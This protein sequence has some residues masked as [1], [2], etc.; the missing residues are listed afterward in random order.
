[1]KLPTQIL[2][3]TIRSSLMVATGVLLSMAILFEQEIV[4]L[5]NSLINGY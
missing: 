4:T 1:M 5:I 2:T 3:K